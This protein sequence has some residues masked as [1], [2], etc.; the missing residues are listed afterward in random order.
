[1]FC[2]SGGFELWIKS[3]YSKV[4]FTMKLILRGVQIDFCLHGFPFGPR[5]CNTSH[6]RRLWLRCCTTVNYM[7]LTLPH[8][9]EGSPHA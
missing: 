9:Q 7:L 4:L 1:M 2:L 8:T 6:L 5:L 3:L